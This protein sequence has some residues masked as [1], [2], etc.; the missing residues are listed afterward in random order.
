MPTL[1]D[2][3]LAA[4]RTRLETDPQLRRE[5]LAAPLGILRRA[6]VQ[7]S[8]ET[9]RQLHLEL[10]RGRPGDLRPTGFHIRPFDMKARH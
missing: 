4:F 1:Q 9:A 5:F 2:K 8:P 3:L 10:T 7:V 6:G